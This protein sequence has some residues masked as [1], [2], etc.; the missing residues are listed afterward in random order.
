VDNLLC[1]CY[2]FANVFRSVCPVCYVRGSHV[3]FVHVLALNLCHQHDRV[4]RGV[5]LLRQTYFGLS[6]FY[7][8]LN[9]PFSAKRQ[10]NRS[11]G[12][13]PPVTFFFSDPGRRH[14][15]FGH[16][17][18]LTGGRGLGHDAILLWPSLHAGSG[19]AGK[20]RRTSA[21]LR[22]RA[23]DWDQETGWKFCVQVR[24]HFCSSLAQPAA[25]RCCQVKKCS[26]S[27]IEMQ[28]MLPV[29]LN[30]KSWKCFQILLLCK[31]V[32]FANCS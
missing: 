27:F 22:H 16:W 19:K 18:Y 12:A 26:N 5:N 30:L 1:I 3:F 17:H 20:G 2:H 7:C 15:V 32:F 10:I 14:R 11:L 23:V 21:V 25:T 6:K 13:F 29:S 9:T 31:N 4:L 28:R 8:I 24:R